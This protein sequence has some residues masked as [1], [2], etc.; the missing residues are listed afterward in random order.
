MIHDDRSLVRCKIQTLEHPYMKFLTVSVQIDNTNNTLTISD[1]NSRYW[2][3][4][5]DLP[6]SSLNTSG[7]NYQL[8][9]IVIIRKE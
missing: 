7:T 4:T 3:Y 9:S 6:Q 1:Y 2:T 5:S 8:G